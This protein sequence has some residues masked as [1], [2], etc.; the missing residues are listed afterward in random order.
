MSKEHKLYLKKEIRKKTFIQV[1]TKDSSYFVNY[2]IDDFKLW[3]K[4][5]IQN[6]V[7]S[8]LYTK[9]KSMIRTLSRCEV[10]A[11]ILDSEGL[12]DLLYVA[13]NRDESEVLQL[14]KMVNAQYDSLYSS[15]KDVLDKKKEKLD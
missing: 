14:A 3:Q 11:K 1:I 8:E 12:I 10:N 6:M 2:D 4:E 9:A 5:E 13:Y 15:G 7:F